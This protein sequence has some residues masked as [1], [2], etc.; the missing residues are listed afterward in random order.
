[1]KRIKVIEMGGTISAKGHDRLDF[2]DYKSGYFTGENFA[3]EIPEISTIADVTYD[4]FLQVS[5]TEVN[6]Q[7]WITLREKVLVSLE[8][9][10]M[11]GIVIT[12]GTNTLEETAYFLHL[13]IPSDK[14]I[15]FVGAQRPFTALSSDAHYNLVQA[16]RVAASD[17]AKNKGVLVVLNDEISSAREV[18][19]TNTYRLEAFQ[20]GQFGY[21]GFID[22]DKQVQFYRKPIQK[23]TIHSEFSTLPFTELPNVEIVYSYAGATGHIIDHIA[24]TSIYA[25]IVT[26]GTGAGLVS[27]SERTALK[28]ALSKGL[29]IVRSSRVGN[30][31]VLP[32]DSYPSFDFISA[33]NLLPQKARILLMVALLK[34]NDATD[35]QHIFNTY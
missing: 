4:A 12:H 23:H 22:P 29:F 2:K 16:I 13:T 25:G 28:K 18:T 7:H 21:L 10:N 27:P 33:D 6:A 17:A 1:M 34:Y 5:S 24:N 20:S 3:K 9:E 32:I 8:K 14:P 30:G 35:I 31:R 19:K 26:A 15:V 11:D